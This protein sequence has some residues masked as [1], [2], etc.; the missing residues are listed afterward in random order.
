MRASDPLRQLAEDLWVA[1][2][3]QSFYGLPVGARMTVIRLA[4]GRLLLHSPVTLDPE[5][6]GQ[7]DS[8]GRVPAEAGGSIG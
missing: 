2:R 6:G 3:S 5:L 4:R 1:E 7:L 8:I